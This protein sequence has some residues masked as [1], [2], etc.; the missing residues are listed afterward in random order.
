MLSLP[1]IQQ[2]AA[3]ALLATAAVLILGP[4]RAA[5]PTGPV[6]IVARNPP[7]RGTHTLWILGT[8]V[9]VFW[10]I[11]VF[12]A[13]AYAYHWPATPDG[14]GLWGLQVFGMVLGASGGVL[15]VAAARALGNQMTPVIRVQEGHRLLQAGPYRYIRHPVYTAIVGVA[16]GQTLV[17][18]SPVL[19]VLT[20]LLAVLATYRARLEEAMLSSPE[21]FGATYRSYIARTGRFLPRL[22]RPSA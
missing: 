21:G 12:L 4:H 14:P 3:V 17:Y 2:C 19:A 16:I 10:P 20:V 18:L 22:R 13:P 7:A 11:G 9:A 15:F 1:I 6:K 8:L 5:R